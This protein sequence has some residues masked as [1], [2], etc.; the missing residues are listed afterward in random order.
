MI[1]Y[2]AFRQVA[3]EVG[4]RPRM[5]SHTHFQARSPGGGVFNFYPTSGKA[6]INGYA[7][8]WDCEVGSTGQLRAEMQR[9]KKSDREPP[10]SGDSF[11]K[12]LRAMCAV[13]VTDEEIDRVLCERGFGRQ[14]PATVRDVADAEAQVREIK[15]R[16][17]FARAREWSGRK[18]AQS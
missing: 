12:V 8:P 7:A 11:D 2:D 3:E 9:M 15:A 14:K 10:A 13:D 5:C 18:G 16:A 6:V 4:L 1:S 17:I